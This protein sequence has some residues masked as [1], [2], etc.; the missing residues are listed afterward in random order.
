MASDRAPTP[1][2]GLQ[3]KPKPQPLRP[4][5]EQVVSEGYGLVEWR[6]PTVRGTTQPEWDLVADPESAK[7]IRELAEEYGMKMAM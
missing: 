4:L 7:E 5:F 3:I 2:W 1:L 6:S